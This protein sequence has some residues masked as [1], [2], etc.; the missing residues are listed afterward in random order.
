MPDTVP[1]LAET[2]LEVVS[3]D[4]ARRYVRVTQMPFLIGRGAETGNHLQL[5]DRRISRNCAAIVTEANKYY[6]EDRGQRRGLF[7][8]GEKTES[9]ELQDGDSIT[10]GLDDSYE[11]IYRSA[12]NASTDSLPH[13]LTRIEHITS[14]EQTGGGLRKLNLLLEAT[15]LLHSQLPLDTVLGHMLDH[16]VSV[17]DADRGLLLE[18]DEND[19]L[20]VRLARRSGGLRLPPES[21]T[22]SQTA[23]QLALRRQSA[24]ITEDLAQADMD[25]QAAQS[26][27]AQRLRAVVV[28]PLYAMSRANTDQSMINIKRGD[29][30]G[31]LYLDSR[32]PAAFSKL[33]RQILDALAG[34]AA[35]ILDNA[36]LVERERERQRMEQEIGIARDIQQALL[37]KNFRDYPHLAVSGVNFPCLAVGGDYFDVFSLGDNR[38]AFLLA[39]VSGKGL[40]AA[41]CTNLL[42][43]ALSAM[44]LGTDPARVFNHV[45]RFL[46]DHAE[47]GR[48]ATMFFGIL[49]DQGHL[50]YINAGHPSPFLIRN[51]NAEDVFTEGSYPV[52]LVPEAEYTTVCLRL[53]PADTLVLFS[54]GVTEAMDPAEQLFGVPRL[55]EVL[56]GVAMQ[57]P[58]D[59]VQHKVLD[60][61]E[62][63]AHGAS[64]ADD[65]TL[66]L[67]RY[68]GVNIVSDTDTPPIQAS[69]SAS[70]ASAV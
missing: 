49:D 8:N 22:P 47:I 55:K 6:I 44:T 21:L 28:I 3:P 53:E 64:Q 15:T 17:T 48:Y 29:F 7:V 34:D 61:V 45:N 70:S 41:L 59:E 9:R 26:I 23:I 50:E 12:T 66:L 2:V 40:G 65:L 67:V 68:R 24:V 56:T 33:D 25:L 39:D 36:R 51:G 62:N 5:A 10:F 14:S 42:Q 43:G 38:T 27:V 46:C 35:S 18:S 4:G 16:A 63:F 60:A 13:L 11:I 69:S 58:L 19:A 32:R 31:V 37:P 20:K 54:D 1:N 52:G 30:L 57:T